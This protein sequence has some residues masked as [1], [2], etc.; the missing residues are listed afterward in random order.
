VEGFCPETGV[1]YEFFG[2]YF[3][4]HTCQTF[5]DVIAMNADTLAEMYEYTVPRIEQIACAG[6]NVELEWECGF[7]KEI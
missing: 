2:C 1:V 3:H 7:D 6:Y 4:G 5:R